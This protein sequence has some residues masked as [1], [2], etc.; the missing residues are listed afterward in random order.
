[1]LRHDDLN[2]LLM[3]DFHPRA[4]ATMLES[5]QSTVSS[6]WHHHI[7]CKQIP[8]ELQLVLPRPW[9]CVCYELHILAR[10][11]AVQSLLASLNL[12]LRRGWVTNSIIQTCYVDLFCCYCKTKQGA[13]WLLT[14]EPLDTSWTRNFQQ[15]WDWTI[16]ESQCTSWFVHGNHDNQQIIRPIIQ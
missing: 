3:A 1:M 5:N 2:S 13:C 4:A 6:C 10:I 7:C 11:L 16:T 8:C 9:F 15:V 14:I 12:Y